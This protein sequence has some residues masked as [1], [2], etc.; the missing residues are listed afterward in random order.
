MLPLSAGIALR[1]L[2]PVLIGPIGILATVLF[3]LSVLPV[4]EGVEGKKFEPEPS[5]RVNFKSVSAEYPEAP[6]LEGAYRALCR[7]AVGAS[8][9]PEFNG[10]GLPQIKFLATG[11]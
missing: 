9:T 4:Y 3:I 10:A 6:S 5:E 7:P 11:R 8:G 2:A 1:S